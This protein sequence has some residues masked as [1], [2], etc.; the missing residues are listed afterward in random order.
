M[1]YS[2]LDFQYMEYILDNNMSALNGDDEENRIDL[3][4]LTFLKFRLKHDGSNI[5]H[6]LATNEKFL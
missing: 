4:I 2:Y 1:T 5:L 3:L 6:L